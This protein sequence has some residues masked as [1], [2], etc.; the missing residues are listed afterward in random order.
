MLRSVSAFPLCFSAAHPELEAEIQHGFGAQLSTPVENLL[1]SSSIK[2]AGEEDG[3]GAVGEAAGSDGDKDRGADQ[4]ETSNG[5]VAGEEAT[6]SVKETTA[7]V[8]EVA[9]G[10]EVAAIEGMDVEM[11]PKAEDAGEKS[12]KAEEVGKVKSS[13]PEEVD[14]EKSS[15]AEIGAEKSFKAEEVGEEKSSKADDVEERKASE[16]SS[17]NKKGSPGP[18]ASKAIKWHREKLPNKVGSFFFFV[19]GGG[20]GTGR[21]FTLLGCSLNGGHMH[22]P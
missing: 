10:K 15:K 4:M 19:L 12:S 18:S 2:A 6:A 22:K 7:A 3:N 14:E 17:G 9:D 16:Q 21:E 5:D 13:K 20:G 11:A 8:K 1:E